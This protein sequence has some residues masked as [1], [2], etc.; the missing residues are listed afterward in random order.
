MK[1]VPKPIAVAAILLGVAG[2]AG[3]ISLTMPKSTGPTNRSVQDE[4]RQMT[5]NYRLPP[6]TREEAM[7][8]VVGIGGPGGATKGKGKK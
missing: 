5:S 1:K 2:A 7:E 4:V 8:G 3:I 6:L